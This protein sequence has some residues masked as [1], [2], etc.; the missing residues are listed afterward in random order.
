MDFIARAGTIMDRSHRL[1]GVLL[2]LL[3]AETIMLVNVLNTNKALNLQY[4]K[5][6]EKLYVYV[7]PGSLAGVYSPKQADMLVDAFTT[8]I[9]QSLNTYTY[10]NLAKQYAEVKQFF[11]PSC[12]W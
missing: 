5:L 2:I 1:A 8:L 10:E 11:S 3:V 4:D 6:R 12:P 9:S 7:V